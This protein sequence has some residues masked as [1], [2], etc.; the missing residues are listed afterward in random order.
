MGSSAHDPK[1]LLQK[2]ID[3]PRA[4]D[5]QH[6]V[7]SIELSSAP[8]STKK[9]WLPRRRQPKYHMAPTS[10]TFPP[11]MLYCGT[12]GTSASHAAEEQEKEQEPVVGQLPMTAMACSETGSSPKPPDRSIF[13]VQGICC[14]SEVPAIRRIIKP[15]FGVVSHQINF[16][17]KTVTV[18]HDANLISADQISAALTQGGFPAVLCGAPT[19]GQHSKKKDSSSEDSTNIWQQPRSSLV[20]STIHMSNLASHTTL[21]SRVV[22]QH[23]VRSHV[24]AVHPHPARQMISVQHNPDVVSCQDL[25]QLWKRYGLDARIV[26]D[27]GADDPRVYLASTAETEGL[28]DAHEAAAKNT[29]DAWNSTLVPIPVILSGI[30]WIVSVAASLMQWKALEYSALISVACG[31]PPVA[32]KAAR[33][34]QRG[35]F[36]ANA[37]MLTAAVGAVILGEFDEAASVAFLFAISDVLEHRATDRARKALAALAD[38][39]PAR[40]QVINEKTGDIVNVPALQIT[41][42]SLV[43]VRTGDSIPADG[44][45]VEGTSTVDESSLTGES[46]PVPKAVND[47]VLAGS[48]NVGLTPLTIRTTSEVED[49]TVSR[50]IQLVQDAQ[51]SQVSAT[52][53]SVDSFAQAYSPVVLSIAFFMATIPWF[54]SAS[55]GRQWVMNALILVVIACPCALTISTPVSYAAALAATARRGIIVKGGASLEA[56]GSVKTVVLDKTGTLTQGSFYVRHLEVLRG[57]RRRMLELLA[58]MEAPSS[59]PISSTLVQAARK[60]GISVPKAASVQR[61]TILKG[62][63]VTAMIGSKQTYVGNRRLFERLEMYQTLAP[64]QQAKFNSWCN[65]GGTVGFIGVEG[66][67]IIGVFDTTDVIRPESADVVAALH[68][69]DVDVLMLTGDSDGAARAIADQ[70]G[71]PDEK[72]HSQLLPEDKMHFVG[73]LKL[74]KPTGFCGTPSLQSYPRVL[75]CGDGVNDGPALAVADIGVSMGD[76][77][78]LA[79]EMSDVTLMES[80]LEKIPYLLQMGSRVKRVVQEN[81]FLSLGCKVVVVVLTFLGKMTLLYAIAS[82]VGVMLLVTMNGMKLLPVLDKDNTV[83][84]SSDH[85]VDT[86]A[87]T[88][89]ETELV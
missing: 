72:V 70:V 6:E 26:H 17:A 71:I 25:L 44:V 14:A 32:V 53:Q 55:E 27:G 5:K 30:F 21:A 41:L 52:E 43:N 46:A 18:K 79:L 20:E 67:G 39:Q 38:L 63:G 75:F 7:S 85:T 47:T 45:V 58:L 36:D 13:D 66:D 29:I 9:R 4:H 60:E 24:G 86:T 16:I 74:Q 73:S 62:E 31:L 68:L 61:H 89:E 8:P 37:M 12:C 10:D 64:A 56:L 11:N 48:L 57:D 59:H 84:E 34:L 49:S 87:E 54:I 35:S 19:T 23:Y 2:S 22:H 65:S 33:T 83:K 76:G 88:I 81:I 50:L 69:R 80:N 40:A 3:E 28:E 78:A 1:T 15:L 51:T 77:A 82:D 42:N